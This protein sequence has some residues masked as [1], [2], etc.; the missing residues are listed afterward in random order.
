MKRLGHRSWRVLLT[1]V[2]APCLGLAQPTPEPAPQV[3][4]SS[5]ARR[6]VGFFLRPEVGSGRLDSGD[7]PD[8]QEDGVVGYGGS[9]GLAAGGAVFENLLVGGQ[10]W[11]VYAPSPTVRIPSAAVATSRDTSASLLGVGVLL[12]WYFRDGSFV[13]VTPSLTRLAFEHAG[14]STTSAW[15]FG[16][17]VNV[18]KEWWVSD[19]WGL[20]FSG[21]L[22]VTENR[23]SRP[24]K[25][26]WATLA[27]N[28]GLSATYD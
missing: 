21:G 2:L 7:D 4:G 26:T 8:G 19:R 25:G 18:G 10:A 17:R 27:F 5:S 14:A 20:G 16:V 11:G 1:F 28:F 3:A 15:G 6:H 24:P 13:A 23:V 22:T 12:N 9:L